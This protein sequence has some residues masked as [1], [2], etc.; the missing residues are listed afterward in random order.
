MQITLYDSRDVCRRLACS[1][2]MLR[3]WVR[4]GMP[5]LRCWPFVR[6][7]WDRVKQWLADS[8]IQN[9]PKESSHDTD[10][11]IRLLF[12]ALHRGELTPQQ[13]EEIMDAVE[14]CL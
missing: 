2:Q 12:K 6:F 5:A 8:G 13:A 7:D 1:P 14:V 3:D 10:R 4:R 9:W 11:P